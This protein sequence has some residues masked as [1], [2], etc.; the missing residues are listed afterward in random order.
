[1]PS[2]NSHPF[3]PLEQHLDSAGRSAQPNRS[4]RFLLAGMVIALV[5]GFVG[6]LAWQLLK[7][8]PLSPGTGAIRGRVVDWPS[9]KGIAGAE[10]HC[11]NNTTEDAAVATFTLATQDGGWFIMKNLPPGKRSQ[12]PASGTQR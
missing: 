5:L 7:E 2:E 10:I 12:R 1:M 4:R 3:G 11:W 8:D 9:G 6:W